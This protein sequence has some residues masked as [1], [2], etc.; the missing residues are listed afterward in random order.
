MLLP[1]MP[2]CDGTETVP[3]VL[4][5]CPYETFSPEGLS[6]CCGG[7]IHVYKGAHGWVHHDR[8]QEKSHLS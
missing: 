2:E 3:T 4:G 6:D 5:C 7:A 8:S 1:Q